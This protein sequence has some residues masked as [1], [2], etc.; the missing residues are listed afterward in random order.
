MLSPSL[1]RVIQ[2]AQFERLERSRNLPADQLERRA[3]MF[4]AVSLPEAIAEDF[5][6]SGRN[7]SSTSY[8][9]SATYSGR[10]TRRA[11]P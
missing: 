8:R 4:F 1:P 11:S 9:S 5:R 2:S 7:A 6:V 3:D 10:T